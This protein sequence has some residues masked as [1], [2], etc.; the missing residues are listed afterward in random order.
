MRKPEHSPS[1][2]R[3]FLGVTIIVVAVT[4]SAYIAVVIATEGVG[5]AALPIA[6]AAILGISL[7]RL[8]M[9]SA[10]R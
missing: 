9:S 8:W 4:V 2:R 10:P 1:R 3:T 6:L 5:S 7:A